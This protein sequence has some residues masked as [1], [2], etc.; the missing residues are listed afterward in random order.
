[1]TTEAI[2]LA[3]T[4]VLASGVGATF[5][6]ILQRHY[7]Q[8]D[9]KTVHDV[10]KQAISDS[11]LEKILTEIHEITDAQRVSAWIFSNGGYF[12]T[13]HAMQHLS[14]V[15]EAKDK[16]VDPIKDKSQRLPLHLFSRNLSKLVTSEDGF[17]QEY[18]EL[19]YNDALAKMNADSGAIA[20]AFFSLKNKEGKLVGY[21]KL[22]FDH[23]RM[24]TA[25]EVNLIRAY[26]PTIEAELKSK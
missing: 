14:M 8:K 23:H 16:E 12:Y 21:V 10:V 2:V 6:V 25:A 17:F 7:S 15:A 9:K 19:Q 3:A 11:K 5:G 26:V 18:N 24:L 13:G 20:T 1:M 22:G 4:T